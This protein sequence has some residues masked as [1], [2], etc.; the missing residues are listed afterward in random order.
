MH[1][2]HHRSD[3]RLFV[4]VKVR[5]D[6]LAQIIASVIGRSCINREVGNL[7]SVAAVGCC[8]LGK[9]NLRSY[10]PLEVKMCSIEGTGDIKTGLNESCRNQS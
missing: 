10:S 3:E 9:C 4:C 7:V 5:F 2:G 1:G 8:D 6:L